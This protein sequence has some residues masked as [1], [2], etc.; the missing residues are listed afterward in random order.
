[1]ALLDD[2]LTRSQLEALRGGL[3]NGN[4]AADLAVPVPN[5]KHPEPDS[6]IRRVTSDLP[7]CALDGCD[8]PVTGRGAKFCCRQHQKKDSWQR[9]GR[10]RTAVVP[11][12]ARNGTG[13][14]EASSVPSGLL[15]PGP[16]EQLVA[17]AGMLPAG[18]RMEATASSVVVSWSA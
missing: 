10:S 14:G 7:V 12:E 13:M 2:S 1:M 5:G 6:S 9:S 18:W 17:A 16:L 4:G 8:R 11:R 15:W 3:D